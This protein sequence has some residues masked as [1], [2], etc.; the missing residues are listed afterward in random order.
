[1]SLETQ[2]ETLNQ[3]ANESR[4]LLWNI[5]DGIDTRIPSAYDCTQH[6]GI[7]WIVLSLR[8]TL[9]DLIE[10]MQWFVYGYS[11]GFNYVYWYNVHHGL[12]EQETEITW[13]TI[14]EAWAKNNFEGR[15]VTIAFIDRMRQL[16][17]DE[18]FFIA[19]A[20]KPEKEF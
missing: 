13:K 20:A 10:S 9:Y 8:T 5:E 3:W 6:G 19:W 11:S 14:C 18:P 12:F 4:L 1:M 16:I 15:A 2:I 7:G 17:W